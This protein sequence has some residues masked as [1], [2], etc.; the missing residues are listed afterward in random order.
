MQLGDDDGEDDGE[1]KMPS[2]SDYV[3]HFITLFWKV[4]FAF[5]P[6]TGNYKNKTDQC[7]VRLL[8]E[9]TLTLICLQIFGVVGPVS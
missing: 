3:M 9:L 8:S 2:C 7:P 6:P 4:L 1:Q 5:V